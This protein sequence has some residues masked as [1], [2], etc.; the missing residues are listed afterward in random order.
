MFNINTLNPSAVTY[1][2]IVSPGTKF[3]NNEIV[4]LDD[5]YVPAESDNPV[6]AS[7]KSVM[8]IQKLSQS[9]YEG[10]DYSEM[11]PV[12]RKNSRIVNGKH[13]LYELVCGNHRYEAL[14][15]I[16]FDRWIFSIYEFALNNVSFEDSVRTFQLMENNHNP[17][18][19]SSE[20]D[21]ANII[22]RLI[23]YGS[24]LV[25]NT[26]KS[27]RAYVDTYCTK[28]HHNT[29]AKIVRQVIRNC[30]TY[31][32]VVT[33]TS[34][35]AFKWIEENTTYVVAGNH[36]NNRKKFGWTVL[37]GYEYE[38]IMSAAKK[39][40]ESGRESY[41]LCHTKAPTEQF[42]LTEKRKKM[43]N[44]F[45]ELEDSLKEVFEYYKK[46]NRF[47]W[48]VEGFLPQDHQAGESGRLI[49]AV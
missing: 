18:L 25:D 41:F 14:Q 15:S 24:K 28:V 44:T 30:G 36:D 32:D 38:Y 10:I 49:P 43:M 45:A 3:I 12:V 16:G 48:S 4:S 35:D 8:N 19:P 31:Q 9:F 33:Y 1:R 26:E 46:H 17:A 34:K 2:P 20:D 13:Y 27:I 21:I 6:R 23:V 39:F 7:G 47:P 11:P 5:I 40:S 22:T 37:E 42:P 29:K